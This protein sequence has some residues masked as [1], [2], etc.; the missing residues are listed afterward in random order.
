MTTTALVRPVF[1]KVLQIPALVMARP[2]ATTRQRNGV[3]DR[4]VLFARNGTLPH[5]K[6]VDSLTVWPTEVVPST[7]MTGGV[8]VET[9][10][11]PAE[12]TA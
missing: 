5:R 12:F 3:S 10:L 8:G 6:T 11:E 7:A 1:T 2:L 9:G 4:M